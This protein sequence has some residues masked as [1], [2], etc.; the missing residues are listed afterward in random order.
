MGWDT[1]TTR[2]SGL[3]V[4]LTEPIFFHRFA[5]NECDTLSQHQFIPLRCEDF[6][7]QLTV[8]QLS[9]FG[10]ELKELR[11]QAVQ[12]SWSEVEIAIVVD[13]SHAPIIR[14]CVAVATPAFK[15]D[16]KFSGKCMW[17]CRSE[18]LG[19][20]EGVFEEL[21]DSDG[22]LRILPRD[23]TAITNRMRGEVLTALKQS[24]QF[25]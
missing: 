15:I 6:S 17:I 13:K 4:T 22:R 5:L 1:R 11:F 3:V 21:A 23:E 2:S 7:P 12:L 8:A 14:R 18:T 20:S 16:G 25:P 19:L 24:T 9:E 10:L